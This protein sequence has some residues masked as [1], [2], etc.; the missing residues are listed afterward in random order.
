M[1]K[2]KLLIAESSEELRMALSDLFRDSCQVRVCSDGD[3]AQRELRTFRPDVLVLD[4]MLP[5]YD[6]ISLL[7]W[8]RDQGICPVVLAT[9]RFCNDYVVESVQQLGVGYLMIKPCR[10]SAL[11]E[12]IGDLNRRLQPIAPTSADPNTRI[13]SQLQALGIPTK[14]RG[15]TYLREAVAVYAQD[16]LQSVTKSLYPQVAKRCGCAPS[17]VE[18]CIRS[19]IDTAW[20]N[21]D[22]EIWK[23]YFHQGADGCIPRPTNGAFISRLAD[24]LKTGTESGSFTSEIAQNTRKKSTNASE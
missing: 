10:L 6:G 4:L 19:A 16:P 18:R 5:G 14:L 13:G 12:R 24:S 2:R 7:Q 22:E 17:H 15:S 11:A 21:R 23:L 9:T 20:K 1:Q 3:S 8:A